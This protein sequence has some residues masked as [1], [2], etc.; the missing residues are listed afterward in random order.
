MAAN[1]TTTAEGI[2]KKV[3]GQIRDKRPTVAKAP[4]QNQIGF[5]EGNKLGDVFSETL[6]LADEAGITYGGSTSDLFALNDSV[7]G[8]SKEVSASGCEIVIRAQVAMKRLTTAMKKG[9]AAF[10][11]FWGRLLKNNKN[12]IG[13]RVDISL[14][15]GGD[16]IG[17]VT[18]TPS[19]SSGAR[20]MTLTAASWLPLAFLG[21]KGAR[22][23]VYS[24]GGTHRNP[25]TD[26]VVTSVTPSKT[27]PL[28]A[29]SGLEAEIDTIADTD[30]IYFKGAKDNECDGLT[31]IAGLTGSEEY[32]G[33][34]ANS[35]PDLWSGNPKAVGGNFSF[36]I[37]QDAIMESQA[38][39]GGFPMYKFYPAHATWTTLASSMS[40]LRAIDSSY[41]TETTE[42]GQKRLRFYCGGA[43]VS[44]EP[45]L[46][47]KQGEA[48]LIPTSDDADMK[49]IGSADV[50]FH[51]PGMG[52][53]YFHILNDNHGVEARAYS[54]QFL[55]VTCINSLVHFTGITHS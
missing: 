34:A 5:S 30:E 44:I 12:S 14:M 47:M 23:D 42:Y 50:N 55:W 32:L 6:W 35:Y 17:V 49:R 26:I 38:R 8:E 54:D 53:Q 15:F 52:D 22:L 39:G 25:T 33:L 11:S 28:V 20:V 13:K 51:V 7:P 18:G 40:A 41:K 3:Y 37:L 45:T 43:E 2:A 46:N 48:V 4:L 21:A 27:S 36:A 9:E 24:S 16:N 19:G 29:I 1:T 10:E 31:K